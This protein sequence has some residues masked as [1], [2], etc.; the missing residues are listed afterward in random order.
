MINTKNNS[1]ITNI[2]LSILFSISFSA[3]AFSDNP[4]PQRDYTVTSPNGIFIIVVFCDESWRDKIIDEK[5]RNTYKYP[6]IYT[7][8]GLLI[9]R[10]DKHIWQAIISDNGI[11]FGLGQ[12]AETD[13]YDEPSF[14]IC[15]NNEMKPY[16][17][18]EII[19]NLDNLPRSV[20]HYKTI[21]SIDYIIER[22]Q[23]VIITYESKALVF[24]HETGEKI[25]IKKR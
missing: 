4:A 21:Y 6:G 1:V 5:I 17:P 8:D 11:G 16:K 15:K 24:N 22:G 13:N 10:I 3:S 25:D 12:W 7:K 2:I 9:S 18:K 20:S 23:I 14:Y 19:S